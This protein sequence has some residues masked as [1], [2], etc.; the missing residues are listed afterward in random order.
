MITLLLFDI[1]KLH[2]TNVL[3]IP[4]YNIATLLIMGVKNVKGQIS[5]FN[6]RLFLLD[7]SFFL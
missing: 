7:N 1:E 3:A 5:N 2:F 4:R 6:C